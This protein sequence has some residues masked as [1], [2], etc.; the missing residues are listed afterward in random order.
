MVPQFSLLYLKFAG[1]TTKVVNRIRVKRDISENFLLLHYL[2]ESDIQLCMSKVQKSSGLT[3]RNMVCCVCK[4]VEYL[5]CFTYVGTYSILCMALFF[6]WQSNMLFPFEILLACIPYMTPC[7]LMGN[8]I[9][10]HWIKIQ[11][12]SKVIFKP[13]KFW[14]CF[15]SFFK[16]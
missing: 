11:F 8:R 15:S 6:C 7:L 10:N 16:L 13:L 3:Y 1:F 9:N 5:I 12:H 4:S 14:F 2:L